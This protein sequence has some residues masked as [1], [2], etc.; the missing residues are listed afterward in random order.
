MRK[1][2]SAVAAASVA[3]DRTHRMR[4]H[5]TGSERRPR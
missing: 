2:T 3:V 4:D 1:V 5:R